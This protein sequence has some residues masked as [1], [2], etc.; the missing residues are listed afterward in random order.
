MNIETVTKDDLEIIHHL[1]RS[2]YERLIK[3]EFTEEGQEVFQEFIRPV[4]IRKRVIEENTPALKAVVGGSLVGYIELKNLSRISLF[5]VSGAFQNRGIG[6]ALL[7]K[8]ENYLPPKLQKLEVHSST[9]AV[10]AY[11]KLGFTQTGA[12]LVDWGIKYTPMEKSL[13]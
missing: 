12:P 9:V 5:F 6:R 13:H 2:E 1:I 3:D 8:I 10:K 7:E 11:K 4:S